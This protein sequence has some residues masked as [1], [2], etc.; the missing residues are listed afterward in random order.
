MEFLDDGIIT[1]REWLERC[2]ITEVLVQPF[3]NM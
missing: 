1:E 2:G 3:E